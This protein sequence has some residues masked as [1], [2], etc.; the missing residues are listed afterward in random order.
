MNDNKWVAVKDTVSPYLYSV[1]E[2]RYLDLP[3]G[4]K[5]SYY[6]TIAANIGDKESAEMLASSKRTYAALQ[7][8]LEFLNA[9][10]ANTSNNPKALESI[11]AIRNFVEYKLE[12]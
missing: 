8:T 1:V 5:E 9:H 6:V 7:K 2:E 10:L 4:L 12:N 11:T 3:G